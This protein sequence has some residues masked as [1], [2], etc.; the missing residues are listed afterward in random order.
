MI[1]VLAIYA[2]ELEKGKSVREAYQ[3][4]RTE[5]H[6]ALQL[7]QPFPSTSTHCSACCREIL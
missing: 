6:A 3:G 1:D 5:V 7:E 4:T 2:A